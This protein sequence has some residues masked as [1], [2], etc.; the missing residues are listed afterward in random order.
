MPKSTNAFSYFDVNSDEW[1]VGYYSEVDMGG[2]PA[3]LLNSFI[4][5]GPGL[6]KDFLTFDGVFTIGATFTG[7]GGFIGG[8]LELGIAIEHK[9]DYFKV[10]PYL[11]WEHAVGADLSAG[12]I[13]NYHMPIKGT[14]DM[15]AIEGW[16]ESYNLGIWNFDGT[17]GGNS[18]DP[19]LNPN[20]YSDFHSKYHTYGFG[21]STGLPLGFTKN[22]GFTF[23]PF[24]D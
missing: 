19:W 14:L 11:A 15:K 18:T 17:Y 5:G 4:E 21:L 7:S 12:L 1:A 9:P 20:N 8:S 3:A 22:K 23:I 13:A 16:S 6:G 24:N 2:G 10:R